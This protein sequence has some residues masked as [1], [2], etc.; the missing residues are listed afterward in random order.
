MG[1][2]V[3]KM[4]DAGRPDLLSVK[5]DDLQIGLY[6]TL[7]CSW[8][9]HPFLSNSFKVKSPSDIA[10]IRGLGL[11]Q[12]ACDPA[13]SDPAALTALACKQ[14]RHEPQETAHASILLRHE[15]EPVQKKPLPEEQLQASLDCQRTLKR[16]GSAYVDVGR[17]SADV[18]K[19]VGA[20]REE[21][22]TSGSRVID[23]LAQLL[24][25]D[26]TS[27]AIVNL[28]HFKDLH[29]AT[30]LHALHVCILSM[31]VGRDFGLRPEDLRHLGM[32]A[33]FHDVGEQRVPT[34]VLY[35][36]TPLTR[37]E[38]SF[39]HLHPQF[40]REIVAQI[41]SFPEPSADVILQHHERLDG[42]GYPRGL[43]DRHLSLLSKIVMVVDEYDVLIN[44]PDPARNLTPTEALSH[45]YVH[46]QGKLAVDVIVALVRTLSVY[47][48][49]TLVELTDGSTG[50]VVSL[51]FEARVQPMVM[52]YD[53]DVS[54]DTPRIVNLAEHRALSITRSLRPKDI[55]P[56]VLDYLNP[57]RMAGYFVTHSID[58]LQDAAPLR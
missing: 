30:T 9:K 38:R 43:K 47:P 24:L 49:G 29:H 33:L 41:P 14:H 6:V 23:S 52:L 53:P 20:G 18:L 37:A 36:T 46:R 1:E 22:V 11:T 42:S 12:V 50:I 31:M 55:P 40:G 26:T 34:Q 57:K 35:K 16:A 3:S 51:N 45:L 44:N 19:D 4:D 17:R 25:N 21:A 13:R 48:P 58:A 32:G 27:M 7:T 2:P 10:T 15:P 5:T 54:Q 28:L 39:L 56:H 8:F